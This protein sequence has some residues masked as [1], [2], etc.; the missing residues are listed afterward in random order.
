MNMYK[1]PE[2]PDYS[3]VRERQPHGHLWIG[4]SILLLALAGGAMAWIAYPLLTEHQNAIGKLPEIERSVEGLGKQIALTDA[5]V[6]AKTE[7]WT[8]SHGDLRK[9]LARTLDEVRS[10]LAAS[11]KQA[12][13]AASAALAKAQAEFTSQM[14]EVKSRI[15]GVETS[16]ETDRASLDALEKE[17][18]Q[19]KNH[20]AAQTQ[21]LNVLRGDLD[22]QVKQSTDE[23]AAAQRQLA[24]F[25]Q[26]QV[27]DR[28][29]FDA[30]ATTVA[31]KRIDFEVRKN[32]SV[33]I[34]PGIAIAIHK[35][36][37]SYQRASGWVS[38]PDRKTIWLR[39]LRTQEPVVL[40]NSQD[41]RPQE[42]VLTRVSENSVVGYV[43]LP[44][45]AVR[46]E[47]LAALL[48]STGDE[49]PQV[50]P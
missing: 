7:E 44:A 32:H 48:P 29:D 47:P 21:Q 34:A 23:N 38:A 8:S 14:G 1:P 4:V 27:R 5:R 2:N 13:A 18:S 17:L 19:T 10:R 16:R 30:L 11:G 25:G 9:Q 35:T 12:Q 40:I 31:R 28:T 50:R 26:R 45:T 36:N 49:A 15:A 37:L 41:G 33:D 20:L 46:G 42:L 22:R 6:A 24:G 43:V 39:D 3:E